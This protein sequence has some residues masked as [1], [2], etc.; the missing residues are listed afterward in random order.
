MAILL[1]THFRKV[2]F[3][4]ILIFLGAVFW[5]LNGFIALSDFFGFVDNV[6]RSEIHRTLRY[7]AS[8]QDTTRVSNGGRYV[9]LSELCPSMPKG[10]EICEPRAEYL[11]FH[12]EVQ[13]SAD[14]RLFEA[15]ATRG[16][17]IRWI[18][19]DPEECWMIDSQVRTV[20][21]CESTKGG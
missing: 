9:T 3:V 10:E 13:V 5:I 20:V 2:L 8:R 19:R 7:I 11:G 15:R 17:A 21:T 4:V 18:G 14:G 6:D 12:F 16:R 1:E